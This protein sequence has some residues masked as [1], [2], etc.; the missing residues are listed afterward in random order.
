MSHL[1]TVESATTGPPAPSAATFADGRSPRRLVLRGPSA[2]RAATPTRVAA[3]WAAGA[4][5]PLA[6][7]LAWHAASTSGALS[8]ALLPSPGSVLAAGQELIQ[9]GELLPHVAISAQRV[10][11]G[12]VVGGA[13]GVA[14]GC[15]LGLSRAA[16]AL[17]APLVGALRAVPSLAWVPLLILWM[18]IGE[19]SKVTLIAIGAFFPAMT[20]VFAALRHVDPKL[21]EM[22][23]TFGVRGLSLLRTVQLPSIVPSVFAGLRLALAQAW[24]FLVAAELIASSMGLGF[25]LVDSQNNGRTDRLI[26]AILLLALLG[27]ASDALL[28]WAERRALARWGTPG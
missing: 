16:E 22:A 25:L 5:I 9:R 27:K 13:A 21:V 4:L 10:V 15:L 8:P 19:D 24:L 1:T 28:G 17:L 14:V 3:R 6:L 26:L 11:L 12:F 18:R 7:L 23:R 2:M 20:T